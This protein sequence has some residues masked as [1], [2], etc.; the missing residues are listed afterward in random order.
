MLPVPQDEAIAERALKM[1]NHDRQR[2]RGPVR[3]VPEISAL[4]LEL[5]LLGIDLRSRGWCLGDW[6][7]AELEAGSSG[8]V[9]RLR[10]GWVR[11]WS[12]AWRARQHAH[13]GHDAWC[14]AIGISRSTLENFLRGWV[15][16]GSSDAHGFLADVASELVSAVQLRRAHRTVLGEPT[17]AELVELACV[18]VRRRIT[19][20]APREDSAGTSCLKIPALNQ[21]QPPGVFLRVRFRGLPRSFRPRD[22]A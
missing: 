16:R 2:V 4:M 8:F 5:C 21:G 17:H 20:V 9:P 7:P 12:R 18:S 13:Q 1:L 19:T 6:R 15:A 22:A 11:S 14:E 10:R 3:T